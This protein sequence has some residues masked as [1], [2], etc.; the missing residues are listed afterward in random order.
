MKKALALFFS[1]LLV[2]VCMSPVVLAEPEEIDAPVT[3]RVAKEDLEIDGRQL[4]V[5]L[6]SQSGSHSLRGLRVKA[7]AGGTEL[8]ATAGNDGRVTF[9]VPEGTEEVVV[10]TEEQTI[11]DETFQAMTEE[12][13]PF[14]E[15]LSRGF[16]GDTGML[17]VKLAGSRWKV[18]Q[19][20]VDNS[21][22]KITPTSDGFSA[23]LGN[24]ISPEEHSL[25]YGVDKYVI[26]VAPLTWTEGTLDV[27]IV[28]SYNDGL[29]TV[30][31]TDQKWA[32]PLA[33]LRVIVRIGSTD[34]LEGT[35]GSDGII[36][37]KQSVSDLA[38]VQIVVENQTDSQNP[39]IQYNG[40]I[41]ALEESTPPTSDDPTTTTTT[42]D[43]TTSDSPPSDSTTPPSS[44][45]TTE[46]T[47]T[48]ATVTGAGTTSID[49]A[50]NIVLNVT[51][52]NVV[53]GNFGL[54][55]ADFAERARLIITPA[56]YESLVGTS[57][58]SVMMLMRHA[59]SSIEPQ[60]ITQAIAGNNAYASYDVDKVTH[61]TFSLALV[62]NDPRVGEV[63]FPAVN[64]AE[65]VQYTIQLPV[66]A[67]MKNADMISVAVYGDN[68]LSNLTQ[69]EVKDGYIRFTTN[70]LSTFTLLGFIPSSAFRSSGIPA[71]V[72]VMLVIAA[73]LLI[74]AGLLI[75]FFVIRKPKDN[76]DTP[77]TDDGSDGGNLPG[78]D[79]GI[80]PA[81]G[82]DNGN[83]GD[84]VTAVPLYNPYATAS[85]PHN[86][87]HAEPAPVQMPVEEDSRDIY[88]SSA[89]M[90]SAPRETAED[91]SLGSFLHDDT[92][93]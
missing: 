82:G 8:T 64:Q 44:G 46:T 23:N 49:D 92:R 21:L 32:Y 66:P 58:G 81:D 69:T 17:S 25:T 1:I 55:Q 9:T 20:W 77:P 83:D 90:P 19:I 72:I 38:T 29:I 56:M 24:N 14:I 65:N 62:L 18:S 52:E 37:F 54:T 3:I 31:L 68:G 12:T 51:Y 88:S 71:V 53:L 73:V 28:A 48:Q 87:S 2:V 91:V 15:E 34:L 5:R 16:N 61:T 86:V 6:E 57:G 11:G 80:P 45:D 26:R 79:D 85:E 41:K 89:R 40:A 30:K 13:V 76:D 33:G 50:G 70:N 36:A 78:P 7:A 75:F 43:S 59:N 47:Q 42:N 63:I 74:G 27:N 35:T 67:S 84:G 10:S 39:A 93:R 60:M 22:K 4:T